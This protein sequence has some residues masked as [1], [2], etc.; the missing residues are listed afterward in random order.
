MRKSN[1]GSILER[2]GTGINLAKFLR[3]M[4]FTVIDLMLVFPVLAAEFAV[5]L[6]Y[7]EMKPYSSWH[8]VH[9]SFSH[10]MTFPK[11]MLD[12]PVGR[13]CVILANLSS[14]VLCASAVVFFIF[15]GF[16]IDARNQYSVV[17]IFFEKIFKRKSGKDENRYALL[18][19]SANAKPRDRIYNYIS[20]RLGSKKGCCHACP[21][22]S[23]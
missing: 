4:L 18:R 22:F 15:F 13:R 21:C 10:V 7:G 3:A 17:L 9:A 2:S 16:S 14:W 19:C 20:P 23:G 8:S 12:N 1:F 11:T 6:I 5:Q